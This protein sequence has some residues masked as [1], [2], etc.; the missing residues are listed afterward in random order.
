MNI[1]A[2]QLRD[3]NKIPLLAYGTGTTWFKDKGDTNF[4]HDL[5]YI[6]IDCSEMYGTEE[7]LGVAIQESGI[8]RY[9][10]SITN[11]VAQGIDDIVS[12]VDRSLRRLQ[13]EYFDLYLIHTPFFAESPAD[14]QR[15]WKAMK[16]A[17]MTGKARSIGVSNYLCEDLKATLQT[18]IDWPVI[19]QI[20]YHPYLQRA[21]GYVPWMQ[22]DHIQ[23]SS[24]KGL[25][26]G[27]RVPGEPL[28][29]PLGQI[30]DVHGTTENVVL[31]AWLVQQV[32]L[33]VTTTRTVERL[34]EC[35]QVLEVKLTGEEIGEISQV[36]ETF[37]YRN[38]WGERFADD[39]RS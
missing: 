20:E 16:I 15:A 30:A 10:L 19:N 24:F 27:F 9:K 34:D 25:M 13:M 37:H 14:L 26:P 4:K 18:A 6:H 31:L 11:K 17:K 29:G 1:L 36:G 28:K 3:G 12:A 2:L 5:G 39:D 35:K 23:V 22:E 7:E 33:A 21:N 38:A 32:I 8:P